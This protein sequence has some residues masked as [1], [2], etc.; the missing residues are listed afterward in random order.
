M[1]DFSKLKGGGGG[2][3]RGIGSTRR[4]RYR[5]REINRDGFGKDHEDGFFCS[6]SLNLLHDS[7]SSICIE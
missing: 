5:Q 6:S 1:E 7:N 3:G 4:R 2:G